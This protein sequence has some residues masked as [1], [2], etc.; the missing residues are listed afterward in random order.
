MFAFYTVQLF[1]APLGT[2]ILVIVNQELMKVYISGFIMMVA[3]SIA[4]CDFLKQLP[5]VNHYRRSGFNTRHHRDG[6][7]SCRGP[8][9]IRRTGTEKQRANVIGAVTTLNL[10]SL[11]PLVL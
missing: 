2:W 7:A 1:A 10:C 5:V 9:A 4:M 6:R 11:I 8:C 3:S